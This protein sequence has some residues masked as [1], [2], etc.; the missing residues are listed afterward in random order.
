MELSIDGNYRVGFDFR[1]SCMYRGLAGGL[2]IG[3]AGFFWGRRGKRGGALGTD[4]LTANE[5]SE[6]GLR[7]QAGEREEDLG[8]E[9]EESTESYAVR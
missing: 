9:T 7:E 1:C 4:H 3:R 2:D 8:V 5:G 6:T